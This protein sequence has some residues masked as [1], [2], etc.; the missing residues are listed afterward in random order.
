MNQFFNE[1]D[2]K[3]I[4]LVTSMVTTNLLI[5]G[6][7]INSNPNIALIISIIITIVMVGII[8]R[9]R[10]KNVRKALFLVTALEFMLVL[11]AYIN[12]I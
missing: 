3:N 11:Q 10:D 1:E 8:M 7:F 5:P 9:I 4:T 2:K 6:I 12:K